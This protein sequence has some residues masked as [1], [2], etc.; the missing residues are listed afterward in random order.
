MKLPGKK[1]VPF[2]NTRAARRGSHN[3]KVSVAQGNPLHRDHK[4]CPWSAQH[5]PQATLH[6]NFQDYGKFSYLCLQTQGQTN[7]ISLILTLLGKP[8]GREEAPR[9][10]IKHGVTPGQGP[11]SEEQHIPHHRDWAPFSLCSNQTCAKE[12]AGDRTG[13]KII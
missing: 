11:G 5:S 4:S 10:T 2:L 8:A 9:A 1:P 12:R 3:C 6:R 7:H 13:F